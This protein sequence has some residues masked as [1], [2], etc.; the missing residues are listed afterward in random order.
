MPNFSYIA[1][2]EQG[3][4]K[5]G[6]L[7]AKDES[8][9]AAAIRRQG[10]F[11]ISLD[12]ETKSKSKPN[13]LS[14]LNRGPGLAE[15]V[16]FIRNLQVMIAAGVSLPRAINTL[17]LQAKNKRFK[18]VL[19]EIEEKI[20]HGRSL[21]DG[22]ADY[23][24]IFPEIFQNMIK[25]GEESGT[26]EQ[27]LGNLD[28]QLEKQQELR[29][30]LIGAAIYPAVIISAMVVIGIIMMVVVVPKL[31]D[32]FNDLGITLPI[33]TRMVIWLGMFLQKYW[34]L[35]PLIIAGVVFA[36]S[37]LLATKLGKKS[38][39]KIILHI[40]VVSK[41][42]RET[43]SAVFART[44]GSL[45]ASG[46]PLIR[47]LEIISGTFGNFYFRQ[48]LLEAIEK[49]KK[50]TKLAEALKPYENLYLSIIIQ[51][52]EVGEETG[53]TSRVLNQLAVFL[54][55]EVANATKNIASLIEPLLMVVVGA[56]V[57][58][59]AV[60]MIQP[61]YSMLEAI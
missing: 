35:L 44:L 58:F 18:M 61:M 11:L 5:T 56:A 10:L 8:E 28:I 53:E 6:F 46:V 23:E 1:K 29:S 41:L 42:V 16:F 45:S 26:L 15:K 51:M 4:T 19:S 38:F 60:S 54:E 12:T 43:N 14:F 34:Y 7:E 2:N 21:S 24:D 40:P 31:A 39:D 3:E 27:V 47:S 57:G 50:G 20:I 48:S 17:V 55:E 9:L 22:M 49:I 33:T 32:T 36:F 13:Y 59:F 37:R 52:I 30:R 25:I